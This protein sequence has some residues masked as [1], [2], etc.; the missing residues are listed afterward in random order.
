MSAN[1]KGLEISV[2]AQEKKIAVLEKIVDN[3]Q[4]EAKSNDTRALLIK[5]VQ[6]IGKRIDRLEMVSKAMIAQA[7]G[8]FDS[9]KIEDLKNEVQKSNDAIA[10]TRE[11][12]RLTMVKFSSDDTARQAQEKRFDSSL[13]KPE[14]DSKLLASALK[15]VEARHAKQIAKHEA[16]IEA[17]NRAAENDRRKDSEQQDK[18]MEQEMKKQ[19]RDFEKNAFETLLNTRLAVL[20][21]QISDNL[22]L[23]LKHAAAR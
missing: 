4:N 3:L 12:A 1:S 14:D 9:K 20:Q 10:D 19:L 13:K 15:T 6:A 17:N 7:K 2:K 18:K 11:K 22:Q 8:N 16:A 23:T 5:H 21:K